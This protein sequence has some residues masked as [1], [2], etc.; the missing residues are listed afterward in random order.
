MVQC[1]RLERRVECE[2]RP[3]SWQ[4]LKELL[5]EI[6][7][8]KSAESCGGRMRLCR[9]HSTLLSWRQLAHMGHSYFRFYIFISYMIQGFNIHLHQKMWEESD[10]LFERHLRT[11]FYWQHGQIPGFWRS[12]NFTLKHTLS[13]GNLGACPQCQFPDSAPS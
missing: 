4:R 2:L 13:W 11:P 12:P 10:L 9:Q 7:Q 1:L 8:A 5:S 3:E 6:S